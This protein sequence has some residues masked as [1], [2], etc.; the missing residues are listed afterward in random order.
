M[1]TF[2]T[3]FGSQFV[4]EI[5]LS[6]I[7]LWWS[8]LRLQ[9]IFLGLKFNERKALL[10]PNGGLQRQCQY[11]QDEILY[12]RELH[13]KARINLTILFSF[14]NTYFS[15]V[16]LLLKLSSCKNHFFV[17]FKQSNY[18]TKHQTL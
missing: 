2:N 9:I 3:L 1:T 12:K 5:W 4:L 6:L 13:R 7:R 11:L 18:S 14:R 16:F 10:K 8:G 15:V 17:H